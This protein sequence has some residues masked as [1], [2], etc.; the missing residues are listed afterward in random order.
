MIKDIKILFP[1]AK[2]FKKEFKKY[3]EEILNE[4]KVKTQDGYTCY[5]KENLEIARLIPKDK[6][7]VDVG[8]GFGLQ[9]ILYKDHKGYIGIQRFKEGINCDRGYKPKFKVFTKN[10]Q[11]IEGLFKDVYQQLGITEENKDQF[12]GIANHSLWHDESAN[13]EDIEIFKGLFPLHYYATDE[14]GQQIKYTNMAKKKTAV[15]EIPKTATKTTC[16]HVWVKNP[17]EN[18]ERYVCEKCGEQ[19][20]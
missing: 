13:K 4:K 16:E 19:S 6:I 17:D 5:V 15:E 2:G 9:H 14:A 3:I 11:I 8:C 18:G 20:A 7:V 12:Y 1:Y 10:A